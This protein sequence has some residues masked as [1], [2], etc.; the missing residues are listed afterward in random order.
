[1]WLKARSTWD[2]P[3]K[4]VRPPP[5]F[6]RTPPP[7]VF[8]LPPRLC[9]KH[10]EKRLLLDGLSFLPFITNCFFPP[11]P[12]PLGH[13]LYFGSQYALRNTRF[14][15]P[16]LRFEDPLASPPPGV[17]EGN[18]LL[19]FFLL[20]IQFRLWTPLFLGKHRPPYCFW[21]TP[22]LRLA[23]E[24]FP[25]LQGY[26]RNQARFFRGM[27]SSCGSAAELGGFPRFPPHGLD[28]RSGLHKFFFPQKG[29]LGSSSPV[30][31]TSC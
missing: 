16:P 6:Q 15:F 3:Q 14:F 23:N 26:V 10:Q 27:K 13:S 4:S 28:S 17:F 11:A 25:P 5:F 8:F 22:L 31:F 2:S 29:F 19:V 30:F 9:R 1:L 7:P 20:E 12:P 18:Y 24:S 21:R